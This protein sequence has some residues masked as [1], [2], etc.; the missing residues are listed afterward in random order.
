M[1][2]FKTITEA[3]SYVRDK[4]KYLTDEKAISEMAQDLFNQ[5]Q[6]AE[7]ALSAAIS[8]K[9]D[10]SAPA[11]LKAA[12]EILAATR[13]GEHLDKDKQ[14]EIHKDL[15]ARLETEKKEAEMVNNE[16]A[17]EHNIEKLRDQASPEYKSAAEPF[18]RHIL[19]AS[20]L[21]ALTSGTPTESLREPQIKTPIWDMGYTQKNIGVKSR[22]QWNKMLNAFQTKDAN[23][24][25]TAG[26]GAEFVQDTLYGIVM[27]L[28]RVREPW[29]DRLFRIQMATSVV[30]IPKILTDGDVEVWQAGAGAGTLG[31]P[32]AGDAAVSAPET[33]LG[34]DKST[35][36]AKRM[37]GRVGYDDD[38]LEDTAIPFLHIIEAN[39]INSIT[40]QKAKAILRGDTSVGTTNINYDG[41]TPSTTPGGASPYTIFDGC[42]KTALDAGTGY[43]VNAAATLANSHFES[44]LKLS[45]NQ[46]YGMIPQ[47]S[48]WVMNFATYIAELIMCNL[49]VVTG[50][51]LIAPIG[52]VK[53]GVLVNL[54]GHDVYVSA[55]LPLTDDNGKVSSTAANNDQ[56]NAVKIHTQSIILGE[57]KG[58]SFE[59]FRE[60]SLQNWLVGVMRMDLAF[61]RG[62][63]SAQ[64]LYNAD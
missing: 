31:D 61:L 2:K 7:K 1:L 6:E 18:A 37:W 19:R 57:Y 56:K 42:V 8:A 38:M 64:Y 15:Q 50:T 5:S 34:T 49:V 63:R 54:L 9:T 55:G 14:Y 35:L 51:N 27:D 60:K 10:D 25:G 24:P 47:D 53:D 22:E 30:K 59:V 58:L 11:L 16:K 26:A 4:Y 23:R 52:S 21:Q 17:F 36:T 32:G 20:I 43:V 3:E 48:I 39:F 44:M 33:K 45:G 12:T 41:G 13:A 29:I 28:V 40:T 62:A 46:E